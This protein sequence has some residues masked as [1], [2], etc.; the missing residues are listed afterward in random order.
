MV[1]LPSYEANT[2]FDTGL[3]LMRL[4]RPDRSIAAGL[5][6]MAASLEDLQEIRKRDDNTLLEADILEYR[7]WLRD[8][9]R[10]R[11]EQM[12]EGGIGF[13]AGFSEAAVAEGD[14]RL[15]TKFKSYHDPAKAALAFERARSDVLEQA[16][17]TEF[18][19]RLEWRKNVSKSK[20]ADLAA[21]IGANPGNY[22]LAKSEWEEF[23][24]NTVPESDKRI[25]ENLMKA[26][27]YQLQRAQLEAIAAQDPRRFTEAYAG[28]YKGQPTQQTKSSNKF[29][30][31]IVSEANAHGL[32]PNMMLGMAYIESRLNEKAQ[33]PRFKDGRLMSTAE[34][35]WQLTNEF[36]RVLGVTDKFDGEE[37]SKAVAKWTAN[38][39]ERIRSMGHEPTPGKT[40]MFYNMGEGAAAAMLR[41]HPDEPIENV[42]RRVYGY[43]RVKDGREYVDAIIENNP[44]LYRRG[45]TAG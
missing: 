23:V 9:F 42:L 26:G 30:N 6:T 8:E 29:A 41:A 4:S 33:A 40:Y 21:T 18:E 22:D 43:R 19:T 25:R 32:D 7:Q 28:V 14:K 45:M 3:R 13:F 1:K 11:A 16:A 12:P 34:G 35:G 31:A 2:S 27:T 37:T 15:K 20:L 10:N 39:Q 44:S 36:K 5:S 24:N 17:Q 38:V